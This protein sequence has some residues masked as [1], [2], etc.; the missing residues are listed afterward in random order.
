[1]QTK[2][3]KNAAANLNMKQIKEL[4]QQDLTDRQIKLLTV[5]LFQKAMNGNIAALKLILQ[6]L[7]EI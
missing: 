5:I 4:M 1:M 6:I 7:G 3:R 2:K